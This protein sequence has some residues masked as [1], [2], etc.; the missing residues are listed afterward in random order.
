MKLDEPGGGLDPSRAKG[1]GRGGENRPVALGC[2]SHSQKRSLCIQWMP[3]I[4][5]VAAVVL[6]LLVPVVVQ[7]EPR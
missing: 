1:Q 5:G 2:P 7:G 3:T 6:L 4:L